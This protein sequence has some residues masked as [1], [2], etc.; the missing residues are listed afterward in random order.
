M[1]KKLSQALIENYL[2][3]DEMRHTDN[4]DPLSPPHTHIPTDKSLRI[5]E[6]DIQ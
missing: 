6:V 2:K 5:P 3:C 1:H 4:M